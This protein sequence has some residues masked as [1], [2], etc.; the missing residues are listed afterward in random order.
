MAKSYEHTIKTS[1]QVINVL[2]YILLNYY[3]VIKNRLRTLK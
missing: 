2:K 3:E 1:I